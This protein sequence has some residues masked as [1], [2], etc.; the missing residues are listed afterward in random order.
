M[1][2]YSVKVAVLFGMLCSLLF[3]PG[4]QYALAN[5]V[6]SVATELTPYPLTASLKAGV[7]SVLNERVYKGTRIGAVVRLHNQ[8]TQVVLVPAFEVRAV[9][10]DGIEYTLR[11]S[12]ANERAVQ[13]RETVELSYM[14]TVSREDEFSLTHLSWKSVDEYVYPKKV[15]EVLTVPISSL[16]WKGDRSV[17]AERGKSLR[18]GESFRLEGS[19]G[20][21]VYRTIRAVQRNMPEGTAQVVA[22]SVRNDG[23]RR[24]WVPDF[25]MDGTS[26]FRV[27]PGTRVEQEPMAVEPGGV[28]YLHFTI[29]AVQD[30]L[31]RLTVVSPERFVPGEGGAPVDYTV[32]RLEIAFPA[33]SFLARSIAVPYDLKD[34][35]R[36]DPIYT[37]TGAELEAEI[38][39]LHRFGG[40]GDGY[41]TA[42]AKLRLTNLH[43]RPI[44]VPELQLEWMSEE[45]YSYSGVRQ[46]TAWT[47]LMPN[48]SY[49]SGYFF[50]VP[51]SED[52]KRV[53]L[54]LLQETAELPYSM[55]LAALRA[56]VQE[57][58]EAAGSGFSVYPYDIAVRD[59]SLSSRFRN[60]VYTFTLK[61][62][63]DITLQENT[64]V[65]GASSGVKL[66]LADADG[67][68]L[69]TKTI[70]FT[71]ERRL[72]SG[73]Q[74]IRFD[75][76]RVDWVKRPVSVK[77]YDY[78][79]TPEGEVKRLVKS[80]VR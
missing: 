57:G 72:V 27:Y 33:N 2:L 54:S 45:G 42:W 78:F 49:V 50:R 25:R 67:Q 11:P 14:I 62:N 52:G 73:E 29:P 70:P 9:S 61:M 71:G 22:V 41:Q 48:M 58:G 23:E 24:E 36:L 12:A 5:G 3:G 16:E 35:I 56:E 13:P 68:L 51:A 4:F 32:G 60:S 15:T 31:Q 19:S 43:D 64:V 55:P 7:K 1:R 63:L 20:S 74:S 65:D 21:L 77:I 30:P 53:T 38:V 46:S 66:E 79:A 6:S 28:R 26:G 34:P 10:A 47:S 17:F 39:E 80:L 37:R 18:W 59:W 76:V 44:P 40:A 75:D 69:S 8:G